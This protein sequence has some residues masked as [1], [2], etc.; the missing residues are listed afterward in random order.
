MMEGLAR[1]EFL[2]AGGAAA[3]VAL[4]PYP[5]FAQSGSAEKLIP[6]LD[7]PPPVPAE[8]A[9]VKALTPLEQLDSWITPNDKFFSI[10]HYNVPAISEK[11]WQ[12]DIGGLVS[13]PLKLTLSELKALPR[14]EITTTIECSG[15]NGLPFLTS[16]VGTAKWAGASL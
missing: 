11:E 8:A 13:R 14:Q 10:A 2:I 9:A 1:R 5:A 16:A 15:N 7:Q 6:W 12:L 4:L 3:G